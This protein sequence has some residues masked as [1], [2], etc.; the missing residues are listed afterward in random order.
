LVPARTGHSGH[1]RTSFIGS[2]SNDLEDW[3]NFA[4]ST[5]RLGNPAKMEKAS[6]ASTTERIAA[7]RV[8]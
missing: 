2:G 7:K 3:A 6:V 5:P 8:V 1:N 4:A